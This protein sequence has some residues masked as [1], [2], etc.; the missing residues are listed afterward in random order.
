MESKPKPVHSIF[1]VYIPVVV[2]RDHV[3]G[4]RKVPDTGGVESINTSSDTE[5]T[6]RFA[7]LQAVIEAWWMSPS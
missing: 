3:K 7:A 6:Q 4:D 2:S 1:T 5:V